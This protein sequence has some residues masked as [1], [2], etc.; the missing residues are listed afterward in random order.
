MAQ[1]FTS[2]HK[3][4]ILGGKWAPNPTNPTQVFFILFLVFFGLLPPIFFNLT[5]HYKNARN[6]TKNDPNMLNDDFSQL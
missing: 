2:L 3:T 1:G 4:I 6:K 5:N